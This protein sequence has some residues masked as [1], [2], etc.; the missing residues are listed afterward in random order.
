MVRGPP[1]SLV[2]VLPEIIRPKTRN[3][4]YRGYQHTIRDGLASAAVGG[5]LLFSMDTC[6]LTSLNCVGT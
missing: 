6:T 3:E 5:E 1:L 4:V 2:S